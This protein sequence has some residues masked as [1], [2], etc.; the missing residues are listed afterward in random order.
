MN[1]IVLSFLLV[2]TLF[3]A[4]GCNHGND[5]QVKK[6]THKKYN[7]RVPS[8]SKF[9]RVKK[10]MTQGQVIR[11]IGR[12]SDRS[13]FM[14]GKGFIPFYYGP[15]RRRTVFYYRHEGELQ[16]NTRGDLVAIKYNHKANGYR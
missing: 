7:R 5:P 16:F 2:F 3:Y 11:K 9:A 12:P 1:K 10:G 8:K 6:K 4:T 15:D 14:T 13:S